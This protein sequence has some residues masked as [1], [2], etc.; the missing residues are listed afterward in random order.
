MPNTRSYF[1]HFLPTVQSLASSPKGDQVIANNLS[2][3]S[4]VAGPIVQQV[5]R[6]LGVSTYGKR[7][8]LREH[9]RFCCDLSPQACAL[10]CHISRILRGHHLPPGLLLS[11]C[12]R[13]QPARSA[14]F[15]PF[16]YGFQGQNT[17][18]K[19]VMRETLEVPDS[20]VVPYANVWGVLTGCAMRELEYTRGRDKL[21]I[22]PGV[23]W[24]F[25]RGHW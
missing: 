6:T 5:T 16:V 7:S 25:P 22:R 21:G 20:K 3:I 24:H 14:H 12:I 9:F 1:H 19:D 15:P 8:A 17:V 11:W 23:K 10:D 13:I 2:I 4:Q 18:F